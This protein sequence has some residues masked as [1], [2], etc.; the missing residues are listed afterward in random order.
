MS[1]PRP[2]APRPTDNLAD[3][4]LADQHALHQLHR[5]QR[6]IR[7]RNASN[8]EVAKLLQVEREAFGGSLMALCIRNRKKWPWV[9]KRLSL[10]NLPEQTR[11]LIDEDI[12][13]DLELILTVRVIEQMNPELAGKVVDALSVERGKSNARELV[14]EIRDGLKAQARLEAHLARRL[15]GTR[16]R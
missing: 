13:A 10:L 6:L 8:L 7:S 2:K 16:P 11:R 3:G 15:E 9:S 4:V 12:T 14:R 5:E 1:M